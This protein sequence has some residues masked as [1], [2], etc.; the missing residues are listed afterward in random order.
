[1]IKETIKSL[2]FND[3]VIEETVYFNLTKVE[4]TRLALRY[5]Q[6]GGDLE[7]VIKNITAEGNTAKMIA[8]LEDVIL[9]GYGKREGNTFIKSPELRAAFETGTTYAELFEGL[10]NDEQKMRKFASEIIKDSKVPQKQV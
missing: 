4:A 6:N 10:L 5:D 8:L 9:S 3:E 1:M 7:G 2:D